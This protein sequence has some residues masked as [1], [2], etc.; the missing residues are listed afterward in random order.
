MLVDAKSAL[1]ALILGSAPGLHAQSATTEDSVQDYTAI[2][3]TENSRDDGQRSPAAVT[4]SVDASNDHGTEAK[5]LF[6]TL[7]GHFQAH[8]TFS[9]GFIY[10]SGNNYLSMHTDDGSARW[11]EGAINF[12]TAARDNLHLG[13][14]LHSYVMGELGRGTVQLDWAFADYKKKSWLGFRGGKLKAPLGLFGEFEDTDT[15]YN[16]ALLP[17]SMYE[18]EFRS[19]NVPVIGGEVYGSVDRGRNQI[20]WELLG[21]RRSAA[22]NDG[23]WLLAQQLYGI[24]VGHSAG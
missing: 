2:V 19:Y 8:G 3:H 13:L 17:Q 12:R 4:G 7:V 24:E 21:G 14:Q 22:G 9:Q 5:S 1:V 10:S 16:W 18:S 15:L 20:R 11:S 6:H 23:G